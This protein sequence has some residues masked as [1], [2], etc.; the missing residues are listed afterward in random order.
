MRTGRGVYIWPNGDRY[1]GEFEYNGMH[2]TGTLNY[3]N[4]EKYIGSW[5]GGKKRGHGVYYW[6]NG[7]RYEG[8]FK[9]DKKH[10]IGSLIY[11]NG[12]VAYGKWVDDVLSSKRV[13]G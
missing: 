9:D 12:E 3:A 4:G 7:K 5:V 13:H 10:G 8:E 2:G 11:I 1:E 6:P